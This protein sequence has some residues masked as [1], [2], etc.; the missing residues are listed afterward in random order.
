VRP[1]S[2]TPPRKSLLASPAESKIFDPDQAILARANYHMRQIA[3]IHDLSEKH[4]F[5]GNKTG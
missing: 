4:G 3:A 5:S 2:L 1:S